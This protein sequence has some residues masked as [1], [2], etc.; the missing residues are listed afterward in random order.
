EQRGLT[1][2]QDDVGPRD[3]SGTSPGPLRPR[4]GGAIGLGRVG[5]GGDQG[6]NATRSSITG[7]QLAQALDRASEREL[8]SAEAFHEVPATAEAER[9]ER[10]QLAVDGAAAAGNARA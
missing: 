5:G 9:L 8:G 10:L 7:A 6:L 4:Q 1:P 2:E 3:A